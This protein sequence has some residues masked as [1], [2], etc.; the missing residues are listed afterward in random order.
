MKQSD[1]PENGIWLKIAILV[2]LA[3][4]AAIMARAAGPYTGLATRDLALKIA[5]ESRPSSVTLSHLD[6]QTVAGAGL[7]DGQG[8][9]LDI[10]SGEYA[11]PSQLTTVAVVSPSWW[12]EKCAD[13]ADI[14]S[15]PVNFFPA[16]A[17]V[18]SHKA[19]Y[20]PGLPDKLTYD[21]SVWAAGTGTLAGIETNFYRPPRGYEGDF[22]R[23]LMYMATV[24]NSE[25]WTGRATVVYADGDWPLLTAYGRRQLMDWHRSDPVDNR[26]KKRDEAISAAI[27]R[28]NPFVSNPA[29]AEYLW[30][31]KTGEKYDE[32]PGEGPSEPDDSDDKP[33]RIAVKAI[34]RA[35]TDSRIDF[36]S[37]F[38]PDDAVWTLDGRTVTTDFINLGDISAGDHRLCFKSTGLS[39]AVKIKVIK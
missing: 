31:D 17:Q 25:L 20:P 10:F 14:T 7:D 22:A 3:V 18:A 5:T 36:Y 4:A 15:N 28:G 29:L 26:E 38:V 16:N 19:D 21:N 34:Y 33:Q 13:M 39:G 30:G 24:Y 35:G 1:K 23:I 11:D 37:P 2:L 8:H 12:P 9:L 27:G 6:L 32:T